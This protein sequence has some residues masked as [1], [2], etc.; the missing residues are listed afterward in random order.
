[1]HQHATTW[2]VEQDSLAYVHDQA[3]DRPTAREIWIELFGD[4]SES[5]RF[6]ISPRQA[7]PHLTFSR[8][9]AEPVLV[10]RGSLLT[11]IYA[12]LGYRGDGQLYLRPPSAEIGDQLIA[13]AKWYP[14]DSEATAELRGAVDA[15]SIKLGSSLKLGDVI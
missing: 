13:D 15:H 14:V 11:G 12:S 2:V 7:L 6:E 1:M 4:A 9:A 3:V 10:L 5:A 8:I